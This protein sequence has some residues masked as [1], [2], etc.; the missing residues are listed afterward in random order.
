MNGVEARIDHLL[1]SYNGLDIKE[2][3]CICI[4]SFRSHSSAA[5]QVAFDAFWV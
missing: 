3:I 5:R 2:G 4:I 1:G